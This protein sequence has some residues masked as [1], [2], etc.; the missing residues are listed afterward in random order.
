[1]VVVI[2]AFLVCVDHYGRSSGLFAAPQIGI[3][4]DGVEQALALGDG[5]GVELA[6]QFSLSLVT[7]TPQRLRVVTVKATLRSPL[8]PQGTRA[9]VEGD[10][11]RSRKRFD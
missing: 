6:A 1:L 4:D 3:G 2:S 7:A 9:P 10:G 11:D 8:I 5:V